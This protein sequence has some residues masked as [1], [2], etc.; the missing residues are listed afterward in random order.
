MKGFRERLSAVISASDSYRDDVWKLSTDAG[1]GRK[2]VY[3]ILHDPKLDISTKGPGI[4]GMARVARLLG[5][6]LDHLAGNAPPITSGGRA[7]SLLEHAAQTI[8]AQASPERAEELTSDRLLRLHAKSGGRI[9]A[10]SPFLSRCDQYH[11]PTP[12]DEFTRVKEVG[13]KSLSAITMGSSDVQTLQDALTHMQD[14]ELQIRVL[15]DYRQ[16]AQRG[17]LATLES[18]DIPMPNKPV[19]VKM[20]FVR[21][22]LSV[23]DADGNNTILN[24]SFLVV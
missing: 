7:S 14:K 1:L 19:K 12:S 8:A 23:R 15:N 16:A 3:N 17:T 13:E 18:L 9:E 22:L 20:D 21:T 11:Q 2:T 10:F 24:F 5:T 4:F 6:T